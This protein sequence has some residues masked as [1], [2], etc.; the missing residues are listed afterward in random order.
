MNITGDDQIKVPIAKEIGMLI[1]E[2]VININ[3][4]AYPNGMEKKINIEVVVIGTS[5]TIEVRDMGVG[6]RPLQRVYPHSGQGLA[7][8]EAIVNQ[9]G[10][11]YRQV[12]LVPG[13]TTSYINFDIKN[14][15]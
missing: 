1:T 7:I 8:V 10:G 4:H 13:G 5:L 12:A 9:F 3:Q 6:T 14:L 11:E 15:K 2:L